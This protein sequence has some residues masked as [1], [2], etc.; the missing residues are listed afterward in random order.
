MR[1]ELAG[2]LYPV[3]REVT[4][5]AIYRSDEDREAWLA[6][7]GLLCKRFNWVC[8]AWC[9]MTNHYHYLVIETPEAN[10][11]AGMRQLNGVYTQ[12]F[13]RLHGRVSD[14][15]NGASLKR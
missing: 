12:R 11:A 8:H 7:L 10:L 9:P 1:L 15:R 13:N 2:G 6:V 5:D 14:R 3:T 4:G